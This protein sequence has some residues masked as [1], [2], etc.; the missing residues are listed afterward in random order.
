[1]TLTKERGRKGLILLLF[2]TLLAF[3]LNADEVKRDIINSI[4]LCVY[5]VVPSLFPTFVL[6][7]LLYFN[8][9]STDSGWVRRSLSKIFGLSDKSV[10]AFILGNLCGAPL[11]A[12]IITEE[13]KSDTRREI[14]AER[15][16]ALSDNPSLAFVVSAVGGGMLKDLKLGVVLYISILLSTIT[17]TLATSNNRLKTHNS[18]VII[19]QS[20]LFSDS[21]KMAGIKSFNVSSFIIFFSALVSLVKILF[22]NSALTIVFAIICEMTTAAN[23]IV[24]SDLT[25]EI[26]ISLLAFSLGFSG[27]SV[28]CQLLSFIPKGLKIRKIL[29]YKIAVATL[30]SAF[31]FIAF[32]LLYK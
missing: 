30:S 25:L 9:C 5:C 8:A 31:S 22:K 2:L 23:S 3:I 19:G 29:A 28:L 7:D 15:A 14:R 1:M 27:I 16:V 21:V 26:K 6:S 17:V 13:L 11:G 32:T 12:S 4:R 20:Y 24:N 18:S 10:L